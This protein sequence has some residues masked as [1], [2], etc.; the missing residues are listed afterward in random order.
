MSIGPA[1]SES[2]H[3]GRDIKRSSVN[4][5][6]PKVSVT[7]SN[8]AIMKKK[9]NDP[10][11]SETKREGPTKSENEPRQMRT[12]KRGPYQKRFR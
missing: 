6:L 8:T 2:E 4:M 10:T 5:A 7:P 3:K 9:S 1:K 11:K 12:E